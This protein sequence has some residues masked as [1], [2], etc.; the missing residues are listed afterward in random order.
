MS[1]LFEFAD[2]VRRSFLR[3]AS[4]LGL[5]AP[6]PFHLAQVVENSVHL[7]T[8]YNL[9]SPDIKIGLADP[10]KDGVR[11]SGLFPGTAELPFSAM[12]ALTNS[13]LSVGYLY[14]DNLAWLLPP[15]AAQEP[16]P[17][18][19]VQSEELGMMMAR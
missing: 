11:Y 5:P 6:S 4:L 1:L 16:G 3:E 15:R 7:M 8:R 2:D 14:E 18:H 9:G 19:P 13:L 12:E 10:I 17:R